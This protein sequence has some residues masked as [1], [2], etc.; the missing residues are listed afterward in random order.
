MILRHRK[1]YEDKFKEHHMVI[2]YQ[3]IF[4]D[5]TKEK[6]GPQT[7]YVWILR[8]KENIPSFELELA[9]QEDQNE[10]FTMKDANFMKDFLN[11]KED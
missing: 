9:E 7:C 1:A 6:L 10:R 5:A 3:K 2:L 4:Y 11:L 8:T